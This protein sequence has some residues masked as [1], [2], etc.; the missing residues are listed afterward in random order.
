MDSY[1]VKENREGGYLKSL[2]LEEV[3]EALEK[4]EI[5]EEYLIVFA[6]ERTY[7]QISNNDEWLTIKDFFE[8]DEIEVSYYVKEHKGGKL[9]YKITMVELRDQLS[10]GK[11]KEDYVV[12][13]YDG[14]EFKEFNKDSYVNWMPVKEL[15]GNKNTSSQMINPTGNGSGAI[16]VLKFFAWFD[17]VGGCIGAIVI[18]DKM[19]LLIS[20]VILFQGIFICALFL[21]LASIAENLIAIRQNTEPKKNRKKN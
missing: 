17:L 11:I 5:K 7:N 3:E 12:A 1:F 8:P 2:K 10:E 16:T 18:G 19:G 13:E 15:F 21:V 14:R 9:L 4:G 6:G 20:T